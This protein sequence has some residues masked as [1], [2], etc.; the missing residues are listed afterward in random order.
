[1]DD[2]RGRSRGGRRR[3][4]VG[5]AVSLGALLA[6]CSSAV[7]PTAQPRRDLPPAAAPTIAGTPPMP[8]PSPTAARTP[9][10][11]APAT[12]VAP[13]GD[14][15]FAERVVTDYFQALT[16]NQIAKARAILTPDA[17]AKTSEAD[18]AATAA[19]AR[20]ITIARVQPQEI[21]PDRMVLVVTLNVTT[22][23]DKA[24]P[25][26]PGQNLRWVELARTP[27]VWRIAQVASSPI[28]AAPAAAA[29]VTSWE[30][31]TA[32]E[33]GLS[34][35]APKGWQRRGD[36]LVWTNP[37]TGDRVGMAW[38]RPTPGWQPTQML[39]P[40]AKVVQ[41]TPVD[42]PW[43]K[44]LLY[45]VELAPAAQG[46]P[47][48]VEAHAVVSLGKAAFDFYAGARN[49]EAL[50]RVQTVMMHMLNS[51]TLQGG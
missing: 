5:G 47:P 16:T 6:A 22:N 42:L 24:G 4:L 37:A 8:R 1:M 50:R 21:Q 2:I 30:R 41:T 32:R 27:Q 25:W 14:L 9:R 13:E 35:E 10:P 31:V 17:Q 49:V 40:G 51:V 11:A 7:T 28:G 33:A 38:T 23:P 19:A 44:G 34:F 3:A 12:A 36:E 18:L 20:T 43:G 29:A 39:P 45:R 48:A 26:S 15:V 46:V